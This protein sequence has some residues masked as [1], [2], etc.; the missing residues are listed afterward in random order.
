MFNLFGRRYIAVLRHHFAVTGLGMG[1]SELIPAK[2]MGHIRFVATK[3]YAR[4]ISQA[5]IR[6]ET[7]SVLE[8]AMGKKRARGLTRIKRTRECDHI[9]CNAISC[10]VPAR[11]SQTRSL[12][13]HAPNDPERR[14]RHYN[15]GY[16]TFSESWLMTPQ[17]Y[18]I[19][20][21][22]ILPFESALP[23]TLTVSFDLT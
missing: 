23:A 5:Q 17:I 12:R 16:C 15:K 8:Q 14:W 6:K 19:T 4:S 13:E 21:S 7:P 11:T 2:H 1:T 20:S 9:D 18:V 3:V 10:P 22:G